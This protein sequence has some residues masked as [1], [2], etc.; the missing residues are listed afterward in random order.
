MTEQT[1][2]AIQ[3]LIL[4]HCGLATDWHIE[5]SVDQHPQWIALRHKRAGFPTQ[6]WKLHVTAGIASAEAVLACALPVLLAE[7]VSFKVAASLQVLAE[8]NRGEAR[9]SQIGK[10]I[11]VYPRDDAQAIGLAVALDQVTRGWDTF[12]QPKS[13]Q[14]I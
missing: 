13:F 7:E 3:T 5:T 2:S 10:F 11:T 9:L 4:E 14:T 1:P 8:L 6:G 12:S